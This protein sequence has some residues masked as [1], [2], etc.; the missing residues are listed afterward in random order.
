MIVK[1]LIKWDKVYSIG[2]VQALDE[3]Y[4]IVTHR[5]YYTEEQ[6]KMVMGDIYD[7][8]FDKDVLNES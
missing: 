8:L 5:T 1:I 4:E 7:F 2:S 3:K 6:L